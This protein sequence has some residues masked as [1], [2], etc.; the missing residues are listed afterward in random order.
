MD[1]N[2][3]GPERVSFRLQIVLALIPSFV[4]QMIAFYRIKKLVHGLIIEV[5]IFFIDLVIS[6]MIS[7][8]ASMVFALPITV[9]IPVYY[10]R[11]W[12]LEFNKTPRGMF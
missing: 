8:P 9:G 1:S 12:T 11:K 7:W 3:N 2:K 10:V 5:A 4:S 6:S